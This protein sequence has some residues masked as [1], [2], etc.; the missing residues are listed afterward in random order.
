MAFY[1]VM[2]S[3]N[4]LLIL[5]LALHFLQ[6]ILKMLKW[7]I[8]VYLQYKG[9]GCKFNDNNKV[10]NFQASWMPKSD[11]NFSTLKKSKTEV[12]LLVDFYLS[13]YLLD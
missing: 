5:L 2:Q 3:I 11:D 6:L 10:I 7:L 1:Q 9:T 4:Y 8:V 12:F 13:V